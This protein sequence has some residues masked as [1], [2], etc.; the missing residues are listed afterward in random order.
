MYLLPCSQY[1]HSHP[2]IF[3]DVFYSLPQIRPRF[4][5]S[6]E[7][8]AALSALRNII[9]KNS[10]AAIA[11]IDSNLTG[12][13]HSVPCPIRPYIV[14]SNPRWLIRHLLKTIP[15][16]PWAGELDR[17]SLVPQ[18]QHNFRNRC[19]DLFFTSRLPRPPGLPSFS[20][21]WP[22]KQHRHCY[23]SLLTLY[24]LLTPIYTV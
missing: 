11:F 22:V 9:Y 10:F 2:L 17:F 6:R 14:D 21:L 15:T 1:L 24:R 18:G 19:A 23:N 20:G 8:K 7:I 16:V 12:I 5:M 4:Q 3:E 13:F